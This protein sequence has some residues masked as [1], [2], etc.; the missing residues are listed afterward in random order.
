M[1]QEHIRDDTS[2]VTFIMHA[3]SSPLR[4][5]AQYARVVRAAVRGAVRRITVRAAAVSVMTIP[6]A[7]PA[8]ATF[9]HA[10][11]DGLLRAHV[12]RGM[13]DYDRF[14]NS[15]DFKSYLG[16][17]AAFDPAGLPRAEQLA[18]WINAYNAY[19]I[20]LINSHRER[21]SIRNIN[22]TGGFI[23][24]YGPW[25]EKL[26]LVGGKAYGLDEIEQDIIR[27]KYREPRIH[28]ALVCAAMGCPPLRSEAYTGARLEAQLEDQA[29]TFL[30]HSPTKNRVDVASRTVYVSPIFVEFRD[31]IKDFGG[32]NATVG[33]YIAKYYP[34]GPARD[35]LTSGS[36]KTV[37]T[38]YD[39]TLNS[40]ANARK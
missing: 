5:A 8:Q 36:F 34:A 40:Q 32:S 4:R 30:L 1:P 13:V 17:L 14:A 15:S 18:F 12:S 7:L 24:A 3:L 26:A 33:R 10:A 16:R 21:E 11:L 37:V 35:V 28:F 27:P 22:K 38:T 9:D 6:V 2:A 29:S 25:K 39:W 31:Y 19:T 20:Q 23:K